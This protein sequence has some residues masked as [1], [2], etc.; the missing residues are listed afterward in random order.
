LTR[1]DQN[2]RK[3][4]LSENFDMAKIKLESPGGYRALQK[5]QR[6]SVW[7]A[8]W[9]LAN[10]LIPYLLLI[11]LM[12]FALKAGVSYGFI[13]GLAVVAAALLV[14][15][16]IFFHDCAH[17]CFLGSRKANAFLGYV[18]GILTF[19]PYEEWRKIHGNHHNTYGDLDRRGEGDVWTLTTE[20]YKAASKLKRFLYRFFRNPFILL[21]L[22]PLY[23][24]LVS[25]RYP[26][27]GARRRQ[28]HSVIFTNAA[29]L[30]IILTAS[31]TI[32]FKTYVLI[33]FPV[34][35]MAGVTGVWLFYVQHQF[36]GTYWARHDQW[37][38]VTASLQGSS[39]YKLPKVLQWITGNIG[40]HHIHHLRPRIPNYN[41]QRCY[42]ETPSLSAVKPLTLFKSFKC[43]RLKLWDEKKQK[44]VGF[45]SI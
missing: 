10:T 27:K 21:V 44:L 16:F 15:I 26:R 12:V 41:L 34:I 42:D 7:K 45:R 18:C 17:N 3:P 35:F 25:Y 5:Y 39:Y 6:I 2:A 8:S 4:E 29:I 9:Q 14:R 24:F 13:L 32:G 36:E 19:T 23:L 43:L 11:L 30:V 38:W 40:L 22:G 33:Q 28:L 1:P 37:D 20:E 31:L